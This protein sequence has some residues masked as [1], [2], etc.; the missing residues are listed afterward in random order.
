MWTKTGKIKKLLLEGKF[1]Q[2]EK[3]LKEISKKNPSYRRHLVHLYLETG[4]HEKALKEAERL[5]VTS[6]TP[7]HQYLYLLSA[8]R[9]GANLKAEKRKLSK[10]LKQKEKRGVALF[11]LALMELLEGE[12]ERAKKKFMESAEEGFKIAHW[13]IA[14]ALLE[15]GK[16][17]EARDHIE[18]CK[19]EAKH[20]PP[21]LLCQAKLEPKLAKSAAILNSYVKMIPISGEANYELGM[22]LLDLS[23]IPIIGR[24]LSRRALEHLQIKALLDR[25][26]PENTWLYRLISLH[27]ARRGQIEKAAKWI[28][29]EQQVLYNTLHSIERQLKEGQTDAHE[30]IVDMIYSLLEVL[31][32]NEII[33]EEAFHKAFAEKRETRL[34]ERMYQLSNDENE[35]RE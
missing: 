23:H 20:F 5:S 4:Q 18:K 35:D 13:G 21:I 28:L 15:E 9:A 11:L 29:I 3:H 6:A 8:H 17:E 19:K 10:L 14:Q 27:L 12:T 16:E 2:L 22:R 7:Y 31:T 1:L 24:L 26:K 32:E 30:E 34:L 25:P 33:T